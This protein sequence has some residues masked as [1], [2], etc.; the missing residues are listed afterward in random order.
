M[1]IAF[2]AGIFA[3]QEYGGI[4]RYYCQLL[5][6][7]AELPATEPRLFAPLHLN[8]AA[9]ALP[10][11]LAGGR[12]LPRLPLGRWPVYAASR[13]LARAPMRRFA[14]AI[15]HETYYAPLA[16]VPRGARRVVTVYDMIH[17]R[18]PRE[19]PRW[20]PTRVFK[21]IATRRADRVICIS[22]H[23]RKDL[24]ELTGLSPEKAVA[25][26]LGFTPLPET[27]GAPRP[28][29]G[30]YLLH[31]GNRAGY[32]NFTNLLRALGGSPPL[33]N[34]FALLCFGGGPLT[35]GERREI[36]AAGLDAARVVQRGGDDSALAAAYRHAAALAYPSRYEG[37]GIPPLEAMALDCVAVC[38]RASSIPEV[39]GDAAVYCDPDTPESLRAALERAVGDAELRADTVRRGRGRWPRFTWRRCAEETRAV[40]AA[41]A[42]EG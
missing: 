7:L 15:V 12:R 9:A 27:P 29:A 41:L 25:V 13:A 20:S 28:L 38:S 42:G 35:A 33:R 11:A 30:P 6:A 14:P 26:P 2:D 32:K 17:E 18:F 23:T 10:P 1:R 37:F 16:W 8:A 24:L 36:R 39:A 21:R 19:V 40:Y 31:V 5:P 22:E 34:E 3:L 4:S